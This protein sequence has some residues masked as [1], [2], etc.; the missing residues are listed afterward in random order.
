MIR[1]GPI[2]DWKPDRPFLLACG[3]SFQKND[4]EYRKGMKTRQIKNK[5]G[6]MG[7]CGCF[8]LSEISWKGFKQNGAVWGQIEPFGALFVSPINLY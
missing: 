4:R 8:C 2:R 3:E 7:F 1:G 6:N 5:R